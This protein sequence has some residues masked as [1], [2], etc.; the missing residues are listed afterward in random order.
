MPEVNKTFTSGLV[1]N[2][3]GTLRH[4]LIIA[5]YYYY[6]CQVLLLLLPF[7]LLLLVLLL[8]L[9]LPSPVSPKLEKV[10]T[11]DWPLPRRNNISLPVPLAN[12]RYNLPNTHMSHSLNSSGGG[13]GGGYI[14]DY[15]GEYYGAC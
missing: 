3:E 12:N 10:S 8:L 1:K 9:L 5:I 2:G 11:D 4:Q 14:R 7:L 13:G 6:Y 15:I